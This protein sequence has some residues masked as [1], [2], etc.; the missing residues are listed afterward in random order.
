[1]KVS[2]VLKGVLGFAVVF[3][4]AS[5]ASAFAVPRIPSVAAGSMVSEGNRYLNELDYEQAI[6]HFEQ[7]LEIEP[8]DAEAIQGIVEAAYSAGDQETAKEYI[9]YYWEIAS[10][11]DAFYEENKEGL[12]NVTRGARLLYE[13][14]AEYIAFLKGLRD[15]MDEDGFRELVT[16]A[17]S[18][19]IAEGEYDAARELLKFAYGGKE[20][21]EYSD[22]LVKLYELS[23]EQAWRDHDY[24]RALDLL[25]EAM[26]YAGDDAR[27]LDE[28]LKV[29]EDYIIAC[30]NSQQYARAEE[31]INRVQGLRGD[32]SLAGYAEE[33]AQ[34]KQVDATL[35]GLIEELNVAFDADDITSIEAI[36]NSQEFE[37]CAGEVRQVLYSNSLQQG[38]KPDGRGTA[39]YI[40]G[41]RPYVY[42]GNYSD[43]KRQGSGRWYYS[44][45]EGYLTKYT[46]NWENDLPNGE[47][48]ID[49]YGTLTHYDYHGNEIGSDR[50]KDDITFYCVNGVMEGD[51]IEHS[52]VISGD[53][54][55]Y[56]LVIKLVN[57]YAVPLEDGT[58]P[59]EID[60]SHKYKTP[61]AAYDTVQLY[62]GW[63]GVYYD[64]YVWQ[65]CSK[66]PYTV[67]GFSNCVKQVSSG[68][69][70]LI[71]Q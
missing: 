32:D 25:E 7:A 53:R 69:E 5:V 48:K 6:A 2:T 45:G 9:Q 27:L 31:I 67:A 64:S 15:S 14:P 11:D 59:V 1:M 58:Y 20:D 49:D 29:A 46:V 22:A 19:L 40:I 70:D 36:M 68:T 71:L 26:E 43:G 60:Q 34:M 52:N 3:S 21:T 35:Q 66:N 37:N 18:A 17:V 56:D 41:G 42:Y 63:W 44:T 47:G 28:L 51:Y 12:E 55:S 54:F 39:I 16:E 13:D 23:A 24:D 57:G 65:D 4:T 38:E 8:K 50:T 10:A 30:K 61:I 33:L 62:D